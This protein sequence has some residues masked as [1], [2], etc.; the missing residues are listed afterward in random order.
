MYLACFGR[1]Q[2]SRE[3]AL[4]NVVLEAV[5]VMDMLL[6]FFVDLKSQND[7]DLPVRNLGLIAKNYLNGAFVREVIPLI[8]L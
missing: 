1:Y 6:T 2:S 5:F 8:P 3:Q 4:F 7:S